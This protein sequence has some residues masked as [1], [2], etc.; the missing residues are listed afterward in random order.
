METVTFCTDLELK[1]L[2][3]GDIDECDIE[4]ITE[5]KARCT[6]KSRITKEPYG[7]IFEKP[8][9]CRRI[10][11]AKIG[12]SYRELLIRKAKQSSEFNDDI[13]SKKFELRWGIWEEGSNSI[14][15]H[16]E[17]YYLRVYG[18]DTPD[19][20]H[21]I[22]DDGTEIEEDKQERLVEFLPKPKENSNVVVNNVRFDNIVQ[23]N[24]N[25][26]IFKRVTNEK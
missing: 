23:I 18:L 8:I 12:I 13:F 14:I 7:E 24:M 25:D 22:Y 17:N 4:I 1:D 15:K 21:Y 10:K 6:V 2:L 5:S 11:I 20:K 19:E 26:T 3:M 16:N 9:A